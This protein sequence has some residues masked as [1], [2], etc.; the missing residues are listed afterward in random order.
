VE[1]AVKLASPVGQKSTILGLFPDTVVE[2][3]KATAHL[4]ERELT[5]DIVSLPDGSGSSELLHHRRSGTTTSVSV[6]KEVQ[7][8]SWLCVS[9]TKWT[10]CEGKRIYK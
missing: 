4:N 8:L 2:F 5:T 1:L 3:G 6:S 7:R 9:L 10:L